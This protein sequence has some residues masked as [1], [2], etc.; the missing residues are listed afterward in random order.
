VGL[1]RVVA[2][3]RGGFL[4]TPAGTVGLTAAGGGG[5]TASNVGITTTAEERWAVELERAVL[6]AGF[7]F[8]AGS[9]RKDGAGGGAGSGVGPSA[10]ALPS[11]PASTATQRQTASVATR[12][13][14]SS[15][16]LQPRRDQYGDR[17][18]RGQRDDD[19]I[20]DQGRGKEACRSLLRHPGS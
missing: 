4:P 17:D 14:I 11:R 7:A 8:G 16:H 12:S 19:E 2:I 1:L 18:N 9:G 5:A 13:A 3:R 15:S 6:G 20:H 10:S